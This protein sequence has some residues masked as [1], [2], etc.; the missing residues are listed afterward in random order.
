MTNNKQQTAVDWL[1]KR[2]GKLRFISTDIID[3]A[4]KIEKNQIENAFYVDNIDEFGD[5]VDFNEW[6]NEKYGE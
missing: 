1:I 5:T 4:K 2:T 6:Y 3:R